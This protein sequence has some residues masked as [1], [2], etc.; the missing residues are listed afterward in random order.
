MLAAA[1][2]DMD[3]LHQL[4]IA[5]PTLVNRKDFIQVSMRGYVSYTLLCG[6]CALNVYLFTPFPLPPP[7]LLSSFST[8][9]L[10]A[11]CPFFPRWTQL[12]GVSHSIYIMN[13]VYMFLDW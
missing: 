5:D 12:Q 10:S 8:T 6:E 3:T 4:L 11:P 2:A 9:S 7:L 1:Q 13:L